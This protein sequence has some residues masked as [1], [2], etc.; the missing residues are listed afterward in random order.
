MATLDGRV[1]IV[2]GAGQGLGAAEAAALAAAGARMVLN[3]LPGPALDAVVER[4]RTA[5]GT[6]VAVP[7]DVADMA[8][9]EALVKAAVDG[10]GGLDVLVNNAGV[11]RDRMIF[12]MSEQEWDTVVRVHLRG[13]FVT[14]RFATAWWRDRS[15]DEGGPVYARIVN[16][17]S[18]AFLLGSAGQAN[19]AAA[20]GGIVSLTLATARGCA[21]HGVRVNAIC[22]RARTGM[23]GELMGPPPSGPD[24][25]APDRVAPLVVHLAG[26][27][28]ARITGEVFVVHG[29]VVALL[30][31]PTVRSVFRAATGTWTATEL[32]AALGTVF[33]AEQPRPGFVCEETLPLAA[34]TFGEPS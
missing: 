27:G 19:Y 16:T 32:D 26:P 8:T 17:A 13:H 2:T 21:R 25:M 29:G 4:I 18:E 23:T 5:G 20:K 22:P 3:D 33:T 6:A 24:P 7:G 15:K 11:L 12:S 31:P 14:T 9:G 30:G 34:T 10:F 28:G 1:A